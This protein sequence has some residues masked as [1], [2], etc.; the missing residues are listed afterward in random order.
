ME[1]L[2]RLDVEELFVEL[3]ARTEAVACNFALAQDFTMELAAAAGDSETRGVFR[4]FGKKYLDRVNQN[5][6]EFLCGNGERDAQDRKTLLGILGGGKATFAAVLAAILV[7]SL[8]MMPPVAAVVAAITV[9]LFINDAGG[10]ACD[11][12]KARLP[13][14]AN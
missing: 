5:L 10:I 2:L 12:W 7:S 14:Q 3:G 6:F 13:P 11:M 1:P 4:E 8:S 9:R